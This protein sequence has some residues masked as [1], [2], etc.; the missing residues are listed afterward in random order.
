[1]PTFILVATHAEGHA[2]DPSHDAVIESATS[3]DREKLAVQRLTDKTHEHTYLLWF[4][5]PSLRIARKLAARYDGDV[6]IWELG[7]HSL[8][9]I[10]QKHSTD[11]EVVEAGRDSFPASDPPGF[12][13]DTGVGRP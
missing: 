2:P 4:K 13:S 7:D 6:S 8:R 11:D 9:P 3:G 10:E 5:A 12:T 1:M